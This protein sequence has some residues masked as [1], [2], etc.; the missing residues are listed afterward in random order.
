MIRAESRQLSF[1]SIVFKVTKEFEKLVHLLQGRQL[2]PCG[3]LRAKCD[4]YVNAD[5]P[6]FDD[7]C[8]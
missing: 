5:L 8:T 1:V 4:P 2:S 7:S 6:F 3:C